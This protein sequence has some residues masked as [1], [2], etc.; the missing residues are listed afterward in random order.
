VAE[1]VIDYIST[2]SEVMD[3]LAE[4]DPILAEYQHRAKLQKLVTT[5][6][7]CTEWEGQPAPRVFGNFNVLVETGR[8][9]SSNGGTRSLYP[10]RNMQN[11]HPKARAMFVPDPG[12]VLGSVDYK[13][14]ELVTLAQVTFSLFGHSRLRDLIN[15]G[16]DLH[17]YMGAQLANAL[18]PEFREAAAGL[19]ISNEPRKL[20]EH[21]LRMKKHEDPEVRK[22]FAHW[23]KFAKPTNLGYPGGLGPDKFVSYA[24]KTYGV[25][26]DRETAVRLREVFRQTYPEVPEFHQY[27]TR[28]CIDQDNP[29]TWD[30][31][32]ESWECSYAYTT[33]LGCHRAGATFCAVANGLGMQSP[34]A[35]MAKWAMFKVSRA[36]YDPS[37]KSV[38]FGARVKSFIHDELLVQVSADVDLG[39]AQIREVA[40]LMEEVGRLYLPDVAVGTSMALMKR[41]DKLAE[42][43]LNEAGKLIPWE[44]EDAADKRTPS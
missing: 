7:G 20:Y 43:R 12:F 23:R 16:I 21:F 36:M 35:E 39:D 44:P 2:D 26:C 4:L 28:N 33:R 15:E 29:S 25:E 34:G 24:K 19:G 41:W 13:S 9:S 40:R 22:F 38:L 31:E 37:Q 8:T 1:G 17:A 5:E 6:L 27:V 18:A 11:P 42:E 3:D 32:S 30:E 10:A 14:L